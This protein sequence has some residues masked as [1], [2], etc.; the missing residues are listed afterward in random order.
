MLCLKNF[1]VESTLLKNVATLCWPTVLLNN[2]CQNN[3]LLNFTSCDFP[4]WNSCFESSCCKERTSCFLLFCDIGDKLNY[5]EKKWGYKWGCVF[6]T[7]D[8]GTRRGNLI[9]WRIIH[10]KYLGR[11]RAASLLCV[12]ASLVE[13]YFNIKVFVTSYL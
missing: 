12:Y 4:F 13:E 9:C 10:C 7:A 6:C 5:H 3:V 11:T 8:S 1:I 2:I